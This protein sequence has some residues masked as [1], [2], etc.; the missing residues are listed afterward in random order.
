MDTLEKLIGF[1]A[2][3]LSDP[4]SR[5][6]SVDEFLLCYLNNELDIRRSIGQI[7]FDIL[8]ELAYDL[9]FFVAD[10]VLRMEDSDYYGDERL[11]KEIKAAL[12]GLSQAGVAIPTDG[13]SKPDA[14][15]EP[16]PN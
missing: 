12:R 1:L 2:K 13:E 11:V 10:P 16:P 7:A 15:T 6:E 9:N 5:K 14:Q 3:A 8:A 4:L